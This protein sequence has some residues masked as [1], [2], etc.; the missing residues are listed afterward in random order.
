M[1]V[2][3]VVAGPQLG[4]VD[5]ELLLLEALELDVVFVVVLVEVVPPLPAGEA[6]LRK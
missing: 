4:A 5:E 1:A 3:V 6:G 2:E